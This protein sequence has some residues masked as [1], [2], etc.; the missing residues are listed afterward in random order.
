LLL[1][2]VRRSLLMLLLLFICGGL[3]L[4]AAETELEIKKFIIFP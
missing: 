2:L 3:R 4:S 1:P